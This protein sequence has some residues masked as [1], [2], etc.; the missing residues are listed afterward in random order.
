MKNDPFL[1]ALKKTVAVCYMIHAAIF[2]LAAFLTAPGGHGIVD[3][4]NWPVL[5]LGA[6]Y[7]ALGAF[8]W[9]YLTREKPIA[10]ATGTAL[11]RMGAIYGL[12]RRARKTFTLP[13]A[14]I[15]VMERDKDFRRRIARAAT[16]R[17]QEVAAYIFTQARKGAQW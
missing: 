5:A 10:T 16:R 14:T 9:I 12:T 3:L 13:F 1:E 8:L 4:V 11:D 15:R 6:V 7:G 2:A 17:P